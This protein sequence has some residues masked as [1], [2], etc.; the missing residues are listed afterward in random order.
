[1]ARTTKEPKSMF[2]LYVGIEDRKKIKKIAKESSKKEKVR[3]TVAEIVRRAIK[4]YIKHFKLS[5]SKN[6]HE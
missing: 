1:M 6:L 2:Q 4:E 5:T 3:V